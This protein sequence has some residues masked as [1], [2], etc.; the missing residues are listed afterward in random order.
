MIFILLGILVIS[1]ITPIVFSATS[2][3]NQ[4]FQN[5]KQNDCV[6]NKLQNWNY[7]K[8]IIVNSSYVDSDLSNFPILVYNVSSDF[9]NHAQNDGD[10][11]LFSDATN[12]TQYNH[13]IEEYNNESGELVAWVNITNLSGTKDTEFWLY[14][15]NSTC[16]NQENLKNTWDDNYIAVYHFNEKGNTTL[17]NDST[18]YNNN[19]KP[20]G[21]GSY[22]GDEWTFGLAG[23]ALNITRNASNTQADAEYLRIENSASLNSIENVTITFYYIPW[24]WEDGNKIHPF[25]SKGY[26]NDWSLYGNDNDRWHHIWTNRT[27]TKYLE[28]QGYYPGMEQNGQWIFFGMAKDVYKGKLW[29]YTNSTNGEP[30]IHGTPDIFDKNKG[31]SHSSDYLAI[32]QTVPSGSKEMYANFT[33]DECRISNLNRSESW[34]KTEFNTIWHKHKF[35]TVGNEKELNNPPYKPHNPYPE[36]GSFNVSLNITLSWIG[37]DPDGDPVTYTIYCGNNS[38]PPK[39]VDNQTNTS[40]K[41]NMLEINTTY[42]WKIVAFDDLS[43]SN[44]SSIW[45]FNT[46]DNQPPFKPI[47]RSASTFGKSDIELK[48]SANTTDPDGDDIFYMWDWDDNLSGKWIG[49]YHSGTNITTNHSWDEPGEYNI[50]VKAKDSKGSESFW[51]DKI[52]LIIEDTPPTVKIKKPKSGAIYLADDFLCKFISNIIIGPITIEVSAS[53][54]ISGVNKVEFYIENVLQKTDT[55]K[56]YKWRWIESGNI[57]NL[58]KIKI[59]VYDNAENTAISNMN[60]IRFF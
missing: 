49:P 16:S 27:G 60:I 45:W 41:P 24:N 17:R 19:A 48:F 43:L 54:N 1:S 20:Y 59:I 14:Y 31:V 39:V 42:Y 12:S 2:K 13:E 28:Y 37:G 10:D 7:R 51:S 9:I 11:F 5:I 6:K 50:K 36:N 25:L 32:G 46:G 4:Y 53:D 3:Q 23:N 18:K 33:M 58:F 47:L 38:P 44:R 26:I 21:F 34:I 30:I 57:L 8:K 22:G 29:W 40:Y 52:K 35:I 56:P 15:G 55:T